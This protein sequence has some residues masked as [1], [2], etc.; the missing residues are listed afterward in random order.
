MLLALA[1]SRPT[2]ELKDFD[3]AAWKADR[4]GCTGQREAQLASLLQQ[5]EQLK[6]LTELQIVEVLGRPNRNELY[7]RNQKFFRYHVRG[8]SA[9]APA[10]QLTIRF[11]AMGRAKEVAAE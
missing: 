1:C 9:V 2:P 6:A 4:Q 7:K 10:R 8:C 11:N 3:A 5:R